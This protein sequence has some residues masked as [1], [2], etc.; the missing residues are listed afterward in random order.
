MLLIVAL[1]LPYIWK[2]LLQQLLYIML[3]LIG[4]YKTVVIFLL[5]IVRLE[6]ID[7]A[8]VYRDCD[9]DGEVLFGCSET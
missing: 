4:S 6:C 1:E 2:Q 9:C 7:N 3:C 5:E 8:V